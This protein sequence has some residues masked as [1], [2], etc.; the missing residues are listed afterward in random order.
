MK[1]YLCIAALLLSGTEA[2]KMTQKGIGKGD[3]MQSQ[4]SHWRKVWPEGATDNSDGDAE[5]IDRFL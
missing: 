2:I 4:P 5:V 3:L 1:S